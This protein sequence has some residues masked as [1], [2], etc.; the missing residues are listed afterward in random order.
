META[1]IVSSQLSPNPSELQH[2]FSLSSRL[3]LVYKVLY[4]LSREYEFWV[5]NRIK[6]FIYLYPSSC[7]SSVESEELWEMER[8]DLINCVQMCKSRWWVCLFPGQLFFTFHCLD[9]AF[10]FPPLLW[11]LQIP[12]SALGFWKYIWGNATPLSYLCILTVSS[13]FWFASF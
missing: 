9:Y 7:L 3:G 11:Q 13:F 10:T 2:T 5:T 12:P 8:R 6:Y 4:E 1:S